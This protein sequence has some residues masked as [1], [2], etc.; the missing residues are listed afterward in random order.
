MQSPLGYYDQIKSFL[1]NRLWRADIES[2]AL[3]QR[4]GY[5][6]VRF[7]FVLMREFANGQLNLR[8]MSLVY[9]TLLSMV[10]LLAVSFSVLKAFGVHNQIEP[11]LLNLVQPLGEK[12][13]EIVVNLLGFVE[14][15][16]V[17]VL[18]SVGLALLLY[19]VVSLIQKVESSF[20]YVWHAKSTR[21]F[22]RRFS[23]YLSV[24][25]VGPVLMFSAIGM[26]ASLM[27]SDVVQALVSIEPFGS[28]MLVVTKLIPFLLIIM[29][30]TFVY[31]FMP[32]TRVKFTAALVGAVVGGALWQSTGLVFA[33]FASSSTKYAA[34]YSGFA[35]L[36]L[37][38][39]WLYLSWFILLLGSQV[40]YYVQYP[41]QIRLSNQRVPLSGR[42][43]EQ[44]ALLTIYWI[45]HR[46]VRHKKP[47]SIEELC[48][49][50]AIPAE[51]VTEAVQMLM[52]RELVVETNDEPS[53]YVLQSDPANM[54]VA[55]FLQIVRRPND[56]QS[57]MN[58]QIQ[59]VGGVDEVMAQLESSVGE[60]LAGLTLR[61]LVDDGK[62]D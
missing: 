5:K 59:S 52:D 56:E 36:V 35:I 37:F 10:P 44:T 58:D 6:F 45:A 51:R 54:T 41:E 13:N 16:K 7:L 21:P 9:T 40:A 19:T 31:M 49:L 42:L 28:I 34:I 15:M 33:E 29:A 62:P 17:G 39:I 32:N 48:Q 11:L 55:E 43:R 12:G 25:M 2:M 50:L 14:N 8:A 1:E 61:K 24:I 18:G 47:L 26:T 30:F 23:D 60:K 53:T 46:F 20:N 4:Y 3:P 57:M 27:N 22:S 38:M